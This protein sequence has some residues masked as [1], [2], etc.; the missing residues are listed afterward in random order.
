ME[1]ADDETKKSQESQLTQALEPPPNL[2]DKSQFIAIEPAHKLIPDEQTLA[3][4]ANDASLSSTGIWKN[5]DVLYING[6]A[7]ISQFQQMFGRGL[8]KQLKNV[9]EK[10]KS[11]KQPKKTEPIDEDMSNKDIGKVE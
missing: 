9:F 5:G 2:A 6:D 3:A 1:Q 10:L 4:I 7:D 11:A 8:S